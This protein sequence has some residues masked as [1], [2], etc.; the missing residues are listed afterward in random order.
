M[1]DVDRGNYRCI[2]PHDMIAIKEAVHRNVSLS[3]EI[4]TGC[5]PLH[6]AGRGDR[7]P[8]AF[9][10]VRQGRRESGK[11][12]SAARALFG[13]AEHIERVDSLVEVSP[14][15]ADSSPTRCTKS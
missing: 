2:R 4:Y 14:A 15:C 11:P 13:G 7:R 6:G 3:R 12:S 1:A 9:R 5:E 8:R 10:Q